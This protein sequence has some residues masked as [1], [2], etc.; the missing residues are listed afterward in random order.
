MSNNTQ[1]SSNP[2]N[3]LL[4]F[5]E[6][7]PDLRQAFEKVREIISIIRDFG[8]VRI[9]TL[10]TFE[11]LIA[12]GQVLK[13]LENNDIRASVNVFPYIETS[14][15]VPVIS[16][17]MRFPSKK[18]PVIEIVQGPLV[19]D[20]NRVSFWLKNG[21]VSSIVIKVLE[22]IF[23]VKDDIKVYS[24]VAAY[25]SLN[26]IGELEEIL[27]D[28]LEEAGIVEKGFT[29]SFYKWKQLPIHYSVAYTAIPYFLGISANP[30]KVESYFKSKNI[31][32]PSDA[33]ILDIL[34]EEDKITQVIKVLLEYLSN[35]SKRER[36][37]KEILYEGV[38]LKEDASK[39]GDLPLILRHGF[40]QGSIVFLT[41]LDVSLYHVVSL[42][43]L[44]KY[45]YR[46]EDLYISTLKFNSTELPIALSSLKVIN[47]VGRKG[48]LLHFS[49]IPPSPTLTF[50]IIL[51]LGYI[52]EKS[53]VVGFSDGDQICVPIDS[54][55]YAGF[56]IT[57]VIRKAI[58]KGWQISKGCL[59]KVGG[60]KEFKEFLSL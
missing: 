9:F 6:S 16:I 7:Q 45:Y 1:R 50:R 31:D 27:I 2:R 51:D 18:I 13:I 28:E 60:S 58:N 47:N 19:K 12:A 17:G 59:C 30:Q 8:Y 34:S 38:D 25:A 24:L 3:N 49:S 36:N 20:E 26:N 39:R 35:V 40:K 15:D 11:E 44:G 48:S 53:H 46:A 10:P 43:T 52:Q 32:V 21:L 29:F 42:V 55:R 37:V 4:G 54:I 5:L 14:E 33:T 22:E 41:V 56:D 57:N 23:V